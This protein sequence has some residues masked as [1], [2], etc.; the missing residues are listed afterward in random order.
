[1]NRSEWNELAVGDV[2][3]V[4]AWQGAEAVGVGVEPAARGVVEAVGRTGTSTHEVGVRVG[5]AVVWPSR[6]LAHRERTDD[7]GCWYC[8]RSA[9][10]RVQ[11]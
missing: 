6:Y 10:R 2:V 1:M 3:W 8:G 5:D 4:H 11:A 7:A 9:P